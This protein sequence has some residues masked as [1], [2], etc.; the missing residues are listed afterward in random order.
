MGL[1]IIVQIGNPC[2]DSWTKIGRQEGENDLWVRQLFIKYLSCFYVQSI[3]YL[4]WFSWLNHHHQICQWEVPNTSAL[5]SYLPLRR[6][7]LEWKESLGQPHM[8]SLC[9]LSA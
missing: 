4:E 6:S 8:Q 3:C 9:H 7:E 1:G 2:A 5:Q